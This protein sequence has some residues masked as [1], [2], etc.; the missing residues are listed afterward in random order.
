MILDK[1]YS[2]G[3]NVTII[4]G[5]N[6]FNIEKLKEYLLPVLVEIYGKDEHVDIIERVIR[7]MKYICKC[8]TH[9]IPYIYYTKLMVQSLIVCVVKWINALPSK[10]E[11][12]STMS[13]AMIV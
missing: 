9:S 10:N 13:P 6:E 1:Y 12:S 8:I 4:H 7:V 3:F 2:P 11:I 5:D